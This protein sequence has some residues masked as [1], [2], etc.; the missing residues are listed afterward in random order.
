MPGGG[1]KVGSRCVAQAAN[2][3]PKSP[4]RARWRPPKTAKGAPAQVGRDDKVPARRPLGRPRTHMWRRPRRGPSCSGGL[5]RFLRPPEENPQ[6]GPG[7]PNSRVGPDGLW[8]LTG[9]FLSHKGR[10]ERPGCPGRLHLWSSSAIKRNVFEL[11]LRA[12]CLGKACGGGQGGSG[13]QRG[14]GGPQR[15][16][17]QPHSGQGTAGARA[18]AP[19]AR[20][21]APG[22]PGRR[23]RGLG[24]RHVPARRHAGTQGRWSSR[25]GPLALRPSPGAGGRSQEPGP[26]VGSLWGAPSGG[27]RPSLR[28]PWGEGQGAAFPSGVRGGVG[29]TAGRE[30]FPVL[31]CR[32]P[33]R[34]RPAGAQAGESEG[35]CLAS[36]ASGPRDAGC[37]DP[38]CPT[39]ARSVL[40]DG[41]A[42]WPLLPGYHRT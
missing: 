36:L 29:Q 8:H 34:K 37:Q 15:P 2:Q 35:L 31:G 40:C 18:A 20:P 7:L 5:S 13:A 26:P 38:P 9:P 39:L 22:A 25:S 1:G 23:G 19:L 41:E 33:R 3:G 16:P 14:F 42:P 11:G 10:R 30:N 27:L 17:A 28:G 21:G 32:P 12:L 4:A 6:R 24:G